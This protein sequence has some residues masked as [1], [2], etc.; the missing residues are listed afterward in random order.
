MMAR[1]LGCSALAVLLEELG[2]VL[3]HGTLQQVDDLRVIMCSSPP[4]G[5]HLVMPEL[6]SWSGAGVLSSASASS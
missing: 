2:V 1:P 6:A 3:A 4:S 5:R